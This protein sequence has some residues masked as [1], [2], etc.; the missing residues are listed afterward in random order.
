MDFD[1]Y[2]AKF[3]KCTYSKQMQDI[4]ELDLGFEVF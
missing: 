2:H 3:I 4:D 1:D